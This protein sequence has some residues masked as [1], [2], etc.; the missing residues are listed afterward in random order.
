M[1]RVDLGSDLWLT[2]LN[3]HGAAVGCYQEWADQVFWCTTGIVRR[4]GVVTELGI[5]PLDQ[6]V[7]GVDIDD[8]G[9]VLVRRPSTGT[10]LLWEDGDTTEHRYP[11]RPC[12]IPAGLGP[13]GT[14]VGRT[15]GFVA[16]HAFLWHDGEWTDLSALARAELGDSAAVETRAVAINRHGQIVGFRV[17]ED[18]QQRAILWDPR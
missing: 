2:A 10:F 3:A 4:D 6:W 11:D 1:E 13:N 7:Q 5:P 12:T 16:G 18:G 17:A 9:L 14:V 8:N 15:C